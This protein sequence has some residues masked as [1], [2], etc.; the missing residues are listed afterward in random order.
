MHSSA[1]MYG[2]SKGAKNNRKEMSGSKVTDIFHI[3]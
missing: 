2:Q 3:N 1:V